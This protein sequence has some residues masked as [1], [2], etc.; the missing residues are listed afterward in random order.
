MT[1]VNEEQ[2]AV[3]RKRKP[4][5][6][7]IV[8]G[9]LVGV[10]LIFL[11]LL[12]GFLWFPPLREYVNLVLNPPNYE[13][14]ISV[15]PSNG[16]EVTPEMLATAR[17]NFS[18]RLRA[19]EGLDAI[20]SYKITE[21]PPNHLLV[22]I[23]LPPNPSSQDWV[24]PQSLSKRLTL[25]AVHNDSDKLVQSGAAAPDGF[26]LLPAA[27]T[28]NINYI[29]STKPLLEDA[30]EDAEVAKDADGSFAVDIQLTDEATRNLN[31]ELA[32]AGRLR[33]AVVLEGKAIAAPIIREKVAKNTARISGHFTKRQAGDFAILLRSGGA[34]WPLYLESGHFLK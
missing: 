24:R 7:L 18:R 5:K 28:K 1:G 13:G 27:G 4:N 14:V 19:M 32:K 20:I 26:Q 31:E 11:I 16:G 17:R 2:G 30:I 25:N 10:L 9:T 8:V 3:V 23:G 12:S 6:A 22:R 34:P 29:V 21:Q 33:L 15:R